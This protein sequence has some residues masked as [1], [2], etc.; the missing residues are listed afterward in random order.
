L[1]VIGYSPTVG[2]G[3]SFDF[4]FDRVIF[5]FK[6]SVNASKMRFSI[7]MIHRCREIIDKI[8]YYT[9]QGKPITKYP[10]DRDSIEAS[11]CEHAD[12]YTFY[13]KEYC[14]DLETVQPF[15]RFGENNINNPWVQAWIDTEIEDRQSL[16]NFKNIFYDMITKRGGKITKIPA[17]VRPSTRKT[18]NISNVPE[19]Y[20]FD[21]TP[22]MDASMYAQCKAKLISLGRSGQSLSAEQDVMVHKY[23]FYT[24]NSI[25]RDA[26]M[27]FVKKYY[28]SL[29]Q[30]GPN[31]LRNFRD[32]LTDRR[33]FQNWDKNNMLDTSS[34]RYT[35]LDRALKLIGFEGIF[36]CGSYHACPDI[37]EG[38]VDLKNY[39]I[40]KFMSK[41]E[42]KPFN[43]DIRKYI[44]TE[45][46]KCGLKTINN[47]SGVKGKKEGGKRDTYPKWS[48]HCNSGCAKTFETMCCYL[49]RRREYID[50]KDSLKGT[51]NWDKV[52]E[53]TNGRY[54]LDENFPW[55]QQTKKRKRE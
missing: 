22:F 36:D 50:S 2:P 49:Y 19:V 34:V 43:G 41:E 40:V 26:S 37:T 7:Q 15:M 11:I 32:L 35:R 48:L 55:I 1:D 46:R 23:E 14:R 39:V 47:R 27:G 13:Q 12:D 28:E 18:G 20:P 10:L 44:N 3:V 24:R 21:N 17:R 16:H 33:V 5:H 38:Y 8:I 54:L 52:K 4:P 51:I 9:L 45:L 53:F 25:P 29:L 6:N 42:L 31:V 30:I